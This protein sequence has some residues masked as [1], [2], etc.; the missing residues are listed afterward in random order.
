MYRVIS[1]LSN[2]AT[3]SDLTLSRMGEVQKDSPP[4]PLPPPPHTNTPF[5]FF[6]LNLYK[7]SNEPPETS[8][9]FQDHT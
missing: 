5:Q 6:H 9:T 2:Y 3:K 8:I 1:D 7:C 4:P